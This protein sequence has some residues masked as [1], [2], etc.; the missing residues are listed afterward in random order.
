MCTLVINRRPDHRWPLLIAANRDENTNRAWKA[1]DRH[2]PDRPEVIAGIDQLAGGTWLG[3][4]DHGV[5][6]AVLNR[7]NSLGY[8]PRLRSRGELVLDALDHSDALDATHALLDLE[9]AAY[10]SFN[11]FVADNRDAW[12]IRSIGPDAPKVDAFEIPEGISMLTSMGLNNSKS[13]RTNH[14]LPIFREAPAPEPDKGEW[15]TWERLMGAEEVPTGAGPE[16]AMFIRG[17]PGFGTTSSSLI[18]AEAP[19]QGKPRV[20]W[21]FSAKPDIENSFHMIDL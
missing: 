21:R 3:V 17:D 11:L 16:D 15:A 8:D 9:P 5:I 2:W 14:Y 18:A 19:Y 13:L 7:K 1:P 4:N 10:R 6:S 20:I 12:W